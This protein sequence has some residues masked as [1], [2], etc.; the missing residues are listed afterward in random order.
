MIHT[1]QTTKKK[2]KGKIIA[3]G[4]GLKGFVIGWIQTLVTRL[5]RW[6]AICLASLLDLQCECT[7]G[8]QVLMGKLPLALKYLVESAQSGLAQ[9]KRLRR[10]W[11]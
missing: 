3:A 11:Q 8:P 6:R 5:R 1:E 2:K 4:T 9:M 10:A 7:S